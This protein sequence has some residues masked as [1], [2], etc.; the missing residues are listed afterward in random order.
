[1]TPGPS[2]YLAR[3]VS[4][5]LLSTLTLAFAEL[6]YALAAPAP[7]SGWSNAVALFFAVVMAVGLFVI[8]LGLLGGLA[9]YAYRR[10]R[11]RPATPPPRWRHVLRLGTGAVALAAALGV[12]VVNATQYVRLYHDLHRLL[13]LA[14]LLGL[15]LGWLLLVYRTPYQPTGRKT[16]MAL[17]SVPVLLAGAVVG[18]H[19]L[20]GG[21][22]ALKAFAFERTA[23][24]AHALDLVS[25]IG[26]L[27]GD[28]Y[29]AILAG[30]DC[31]DGDPGRHPAAREI[32]GNGIDENCTG[33]D[34]SRADVE[35][36]RRDVAPERTGGPAV[37]PRRPWNVV[38]LTVDALRWDRVDYVG[39]SL[40]APWIHRFWQSGVSFNNAYAAAPWTNASVYAM[41]TSRY[42]PQARWTPIAVTE[43][44]R[45]LIDRRPWS[46]IRG[47]F[48][49]RKRMPAPIL[50]RAPTLAE[51]LRR[52]GY[53]T[54]T[55]PSYLFFLRNVGLVRGFE[56][57]DSAPHHALRREPWL[58]ESGLVTDRLLSWLEAAVRGDRPFFAW[59]HFMDPHEPYRG[60]DGLS[61]I[62]RYE[63]EIAAADAHVGRILEWLRKAK[64]RKRTIVVLTS[65]HGEE[66]RDHGGE[67]HGTTLYEEVLRVPFVFL[68]PGVK[69]RLVGGVVSQVDLIPTLLD[70]LG[71]ARPAGLS[72][73]SL[74]PWIEGRPGNPPP[75]P[76][77]AEAFRFE[78]EKRALLF[79]PHKIILDRRHDTTELYDLAADRGE[80]ANLV[81]ERPDLATDLRRRLQR[82]TEVLE[83]DAPPDDS[84]EPAGSAWR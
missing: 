11:P 69:P 47:L 6:A 67:Y 25:R 58:R 40:R 7:L 81:D 71:L 19:H 64:L 1:M 13:S 44:D 73:R 14:T 62:G 18:L 26:D 37:R 77:L 36:A 4:I 28:G 27:D 46:A 48:E 16:R 33:A 23:T 74:A 32:V 12:F 45:I 31:D 42:P 83:L 54:A 50:D 5:A 63:A 21:R 9:A 80:L 61:S 15:L 84:P 59:A 30:G 3:G 70:L 51:I 29:S 72:G 55:F 41:L 20:V 53:A 38:L 34:L 76:V 49:Q 65:D 39:A 75:R 17:Y 82:F 52:E 22:G 68:V 35:A 2:A 79:G 60:P 66:F 57:I 8:P 56:V 78:S 10:W 43:D 24:L